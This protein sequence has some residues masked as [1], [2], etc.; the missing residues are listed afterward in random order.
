VAPFSECATSGY[1]TEDILDYTEKDF[2]D[3]EKK[4]ATVCAEY[5]IYAVVGSPYFVDGVRYNMALVFDDKG[6]TIYRQAKIQLVGGDEKWAEPGNRLGLFQVDDDTCSLIICHDSRYPELVRL[7]VMKGSRLVFYMS[8]ESGINEEHKIDPYRAQVVARAVENNVYIVHSNAPQTLSPLE[9][10]H[11]QSRIIAPDGT[12]LK[13]ASIMGEDVLIEV[14]DLG[15]STGEL[16]NKSL[17]AKF[18]KDWWENG[19]MKI[20]GF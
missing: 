20:E 11:G 13:E 7:P 3:A 1:F 18:L 2:L 9:G 4:M 6:K 15:K 12:I 17:R 14:L 5:K 19:L 16:A 10:S 8:W